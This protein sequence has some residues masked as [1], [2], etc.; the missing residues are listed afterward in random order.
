MSLQVRP[1]IPANSQVPIRVELYRSSIAYPYRF[2][3]NISYDVEFNVFLRLSGNAWHTYPTS[4]PYKSHTFTMGRT[5]DKS[6]DIRYQWYHRYITGE[7][8]TTEQIGDIDV[9]TNFDAQ[10]LSGLGFESAEFNVR[11]AD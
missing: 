3:A 7:N 2:N 1:M 4:R 10:E 9:T 6:A 5:S 11:L 8:Q